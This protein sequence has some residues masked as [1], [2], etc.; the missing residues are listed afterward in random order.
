MK[1]RIA[2]ALLVLILLIGLLA[3]T[4]VKKDPN[5]NLNIVDD[6]YRNYY[7][8]FVLS[9]CD[10]D[11]DGVGDL[12]G[13]TSKLDYIQ[14][15][16][17][18]AIWFM[19][20][21]QS[22]TYHKYDVVDYRSI[23]EQ[24]GTI[25][26]FEKLV[27]ECH[28][29]G[30]NVIIDY[31]IN[32]SSSKNQ[33]FVDACE[34]LKTLEPGEEADSSVCK[35]VDYYHFS[36]EQVNNT[37][38]SVPGT[39]YYYEGSFWSE[40]PD[41]NLHN[42]EVQKEFEDVSKFWIDKGVD[43]FRMDA[44]LHY[45]EGDTDG[46]NEL[47]NW[48]Y[49]Y[50]KGLNPDFYMVS[51]VWSSEATIAEYYGSKTPSMF[52]F[53]TSSVEGCIASA[54]RG[55]STARTFVEKML[56]YQETYSEK[57]PDYIDAPFLTNHDQVRIANNLQCDLDTLKM[58]A[59][60]LLSMNGSPFVYYGEEIGMKSGGTTD[61]NKRLAMV[62]SKTDKTG[63][64]NGPSAADKTIESEFA[65]V[66][67]QL[68]DDNSLLNYYKRALRL[69][70]ENPE[71]ARGKISIVENLCDENVAT[72]SKKYD[73]STI[74]MVYN[75]SDKEVKVD[76]KGTDLEGLDVKGRLTLDGSDISIKDGKII[77]PA[78]SIC[79]IK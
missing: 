23:D 51:E 37:Y 35:Y 26:D 13:V 39:E 30:I 47:L 29:R 56:E 60:L 77:M 32:H 46:N 67:E 7:E 59:G 11:G 52:N 24:Y 3:S 27:D 48:L 70:N 25:E 76:I 53:D 14:E 61:E 6:N 10:S 66:D 44:P 73:E 74:F 78:K 65:G 36:K 40:M 38:Y 31:V 62:W 45:E 49:T 12:N 8:I 72:I 1:K 19:P 68:K 28:K 22:T 63:M 42:E 50:C 64:T 71:I 20:I 41:L 75:T 5:A 57:N 58:A 69:R 17:F 34:Y 55:S 4:C 21:M 54:A 9:Y 33:W 16:G 18:N 15:M 79:V 2:S 43:G